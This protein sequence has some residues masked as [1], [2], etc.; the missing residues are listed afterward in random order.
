MDCKISIV[1]PVFNVEAYIEKCVESICSQT[2]KNFDV[3]LV[4]DGGTDKSIF[5]AEN[6][7][8]HFSIKY[9]I[10]LKKDNAGRVINQGL[11]DARNL[12][13]LASE[14]EWILCIDGDDFIENNTLEL[15]NYAINSYADSDFLFCG[16]KK[17]FNY[18][19]FE[20]LN[21][22]NTTIIDNKELFKDFYNRREPI[23]V[24]SIL[25]RKDFLINNNLLFPTGCRFS[26]DGYFIY[27]LIL[28]SKKI[29]KIHNVLYHYL[30]R[31]NSIMTSSN[32]EKVLT[33]YNAFKRLD[34]ELKELQPNDFENLDLVFPRWVLG[35]CHSS[36]KVLSK[37]AFLEL[38]KEI[39]AREEVTKL[40][41]IQDILISCSAIVL[42][43]SPILFYFVF[44]HI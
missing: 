39:N 4:D 3:I 7:L 44:K 12:G 36:S 11:A 22:L 40:I 32:I 26:E 34:V 31:P 23:I 2:L 20:K 25:L 16:Y 29:V 17:V 13:I 43:M 21:E 8:K 1:I 14:S 27:K 18:T 41:K 24:P 35:A 10:V 42:K 9:K 5:L 15:F 28:S 38:V 37:R 6:L 19:L 30:Q 33:G